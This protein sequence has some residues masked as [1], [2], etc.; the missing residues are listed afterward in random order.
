MK[1]RTHLRN[2]AILSTLVL[3]PMVSL[4]Q[5][6]QATANNIKY[7]L[8]LTNWRVI[9]SSMRNDNNT[10]RVILGNS[11]AIKAG[12]ANTAKTQWPDGAILAKLV[13]KNTTLETWKAAT[14]PGDFVHAEIMVRDTTKYATTGG[15]GFARWKGLDLN[16]HSQDINAATA[17]F[18]C[19]KAA[20]NNNYVFTVPA[21]M[22]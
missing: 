21:K 1:T 19:H 16:P 17:C 14:V 11:I 13:W 15:W 2:F 18:E 12:R 7:P 3:T 8:G 6:V 10:Q 5:N 4:A 22:P 9:G 20:S